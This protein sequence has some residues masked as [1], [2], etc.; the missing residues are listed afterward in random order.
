MDHRPSG[1]SRHFR[2]VAAPLTR[3]TTPR[4]PSRATVRERLR[5]VRSRTLPG[6]DTG[7]WRQW[8]GDQ[9][10][11]PGRGPARRPNSRP[12]PPA[13]LPPPGGRR[14]PL[15]PARGA[16]APQ[17]R[18]P[19]PPGAGGQQV[20]QAGA[21]PHGGGRTD[22]ADLRRRVLQSSA[23]HRRRGPSPRLP[24]RRRGPRP[25][26]RGPP[27]QPLLGALRRRRHAAALRG[28]RDVPPQGRAPGADGHPAGGGRGRRVR[29]P[30]GRQQR[31]RRTGFP[32]TRR[33]TA[34]PGRCGRRRLRHG[35]HAG[36]AGRRSGRGA[37]GG[38]D[39]RAPGRLPDRRGT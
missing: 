34:R 33:G 10:R 28:P 29:G 32:G 15:R 3:R 39:L 19:D 4:P 16:A 6:R 35:R 5:E 25:G 37:A 1:Q 27:V 21:E 20:A 13:A 7:G 24:D 18:R 12:A 38:G 23:G 9:P 30:R 17:T 11:R 2:P 14:R 36:G 22:R 31:A 8:S 26:A